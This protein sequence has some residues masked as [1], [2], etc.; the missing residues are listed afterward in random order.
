M[1]NNLKI[2][3][4]IPAYNEEGRVGSVVSSVIS[5]G[6]VD[7]TLVIDD[8]SLDRTA[9]EA[10]INGATV[11]SLEKNRGKSFALQKGLEVE[12]ADIYLFI[13]ADL[14][15]LKKEHLEALIK[16]LLEDE[17]IGMTLGRLAGGR[18]ATNISHFL[19]PNI[20]GQR[21]VR[22]KLALLLPDLSEY[23]FAIELFLNDFCRFYGYKLVY[24][25]LTGLSQ[26]LKEE[27][28]GIFRGF[29]FR[30][31]MYLD[32]IS[33]LIKRACGKINFSK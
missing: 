16:P 33:Y 21:A 32:I 30:M 15:G 28:Q 14:I 4:I 22:K 24:V 8:G 18:I 13:D 19:T 3:A 6:L 29:L 27:K 10:R 11:I 26:Y 20:T 5:S 2:V 23:R 1:K 12:D 17:S 7:K 25:D 31:K 9:E